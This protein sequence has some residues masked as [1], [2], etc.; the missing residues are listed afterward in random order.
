MRHGHHPGRKIGSRLVKIRCRPGKTASPAGIT[1][2]LALFRK[3]YASDDLGESAAK[4]GATQLTPLP[5]K[6]RLR[7]NVE[8]AKD[9]NES[10]QWPLFTRWAVGADEW[11]HDRHGCRPCGNGLD[12]GGGRIRCL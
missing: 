4:R 1:V 7:G 12:L 9:L 6:V 11:V 5:A 2:R 3:R 8:T 10:P